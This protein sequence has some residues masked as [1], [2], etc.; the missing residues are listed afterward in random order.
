LKEKNGRY[1]PIPAK[2]A[3]HFYPILNKISLRS[4][5]KFKYEDN[6]I[7]FP[8][9]V[10]SDDTLETITKKW[11]TPLRGSE[12]DGF[13]CWEVPLDE[14]GDFVL[15]VFYSIEDDDLQKANEFY[16]IELNIKLKP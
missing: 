14:N 15:E 2:K 13:Y 7:H 1:F 4:F 3:D 11:R 9:G 8:M 6:I 12:E 10:K 16:G 5:Y